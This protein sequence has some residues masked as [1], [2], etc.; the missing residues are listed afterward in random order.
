MTAHLGYLPVETAVEVGIDTSF[1]H[2]HLQANATTL[3]SVQIHSHRELPQTYTQTQSVANIGA[4]ELDKMRGL[5]LGESLKSIPGVSAIQN[6]VSVSKPVIHG[7]H[8]NRILILNNGVRQEG[9]QWGGEH[10]PELDPFIASQISLIKGA[11]S[12]RYG[13]DAMGGVILLEPPAWRVKPGIGGEVNFAAASNGGALTVSG[14]LEGNMDKKLK[15]LSWRV[16]GTLKKAGNTRTARYYLKNTGMEEGDVSAALAYRREKG[17]IEL[18]Y[19][20]YNA[21]IG[22]FKGSHVGNLNDLLLAFNSPE[23]IETAGLAYPINRPYQAITHH[24]LKMTSYLQLKKAG[25]LELIYAYQN[26]RR[27]EFQ[28]DV[29]Y[30]TNPAIKYKPQVDFVLGTHSVD[31]LFSH[32]PRKGFEGTA[33]IS[34]L[35]QTNT[36]QGLLPLIPDYTNL[37]IGVFAFERWATKK[38]TLEAGI[39]Y[40]YRQMRVYNQH[41]ANLHYQNLSGSLGILYRPAIHWSL[42]AHYGSG[43]RPPTANELYISGIHQSAASYEL[44]DSTL[45]REQA[46]TFNLTA[47]Y[48]GRRLQVELGGYANLI[49][50]YIYANPAMQVVTL[51][52]GTYPLFRYTQADVL[53]TGA[54]IDIDYNF[55]K[56][57]HWIH[58]TGLIWSYNRSTKDYLVLTPTHRMENTLRYTWKKAGPLHE[59]YI[60]ITNIAV[61]RQNRVPD[62]SDYVAPPAG[63]VLFHAD[64]GFSVPFGIR[65]LSIHAS[66]YNFT[67]RAY[68]DY[69]NRFRY[70]A[71]EA[72]IN[73]VLRIK[74]SF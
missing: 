49:N 69:L 47:R 56:G 36:Y 55:W 67:N 22:I 5:T 68:R 59:L 52:S 12:I 34:G 7:L 32:S 38:I 20:Q 53:F 51:V 15:G 18:Y 70:F 35:A 21:K 17:G 39:R 57:F 24:L 33:G 1:L 28:S 61:P 66:V 65:K 42:S 19:S 30:S 73:A 44:G 72:G 64:M 41:Q 37:G 14:M 46:H 31:V 3:N 50:N 9:Q 25:K 58:K 40:D 45:K 48:D 4:E 71:D 26:D 8:S 23:P 62:N 29:V 74:F 63:Y 27:R 54:D 10:G 60:G 16:Q 43:W 13:A 2:I 6:G 11:A